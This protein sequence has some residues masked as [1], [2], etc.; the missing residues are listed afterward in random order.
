M[1]GR[2]L[3]RMQAAEIELKFPVSDPEAFR[4]KVE[5]LG[6]RLETERTLEHNTLYDTADRSLRARRQIVRLRTYGKRCTLTHKRQAPDSDAGSR[7]KT[8][9]ETESGIDD[10]AALAEIFAQLGYGPVFHYEKFRTEWGFGETGGH[11]VLDETP[12]GIWAELEGEPAW[13]DA[14]M[15]RLGVVVEDSTTASYGKLFTDWKERTGSP[16]ENM[17][18]EE[19]QLVPSR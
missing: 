18:F 10:C 1:R 5:S 7:Y 3:A 9:I 19:A 12:I 6:F 2:I 17:T 8:R 13:I 16:A 4:R 11:L 15:E 14:M